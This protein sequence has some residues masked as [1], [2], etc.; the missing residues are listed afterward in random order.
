MNRGQNTQNQLVFQH[1]EFANWIESDYV[2]LNSYE[3]AEAFN[4]VELE[5]VLYS[6]DEIDEYLNSIDIENL[7]LENQ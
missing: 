3:I 5:Q 2:D 1:E 4:D 7:I 6:E